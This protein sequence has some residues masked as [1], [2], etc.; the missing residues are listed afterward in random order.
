MYILGINAYHGDA[1]AA[2]IKDGRIV[3]A[4][5]PQLDLPAGHEA[6]QQ[7][8]RRVLGRERALGLDAPAEFLRPASPDAA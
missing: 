5:L 1:A 6:E 2:L 8:Q 4:D 3:A 7:D